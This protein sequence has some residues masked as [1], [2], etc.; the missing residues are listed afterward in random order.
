MP[1][2][3]VRI[4]IAG[5][6]VEAVVDTGAS[7][8]VIGERIVKKLGCWKRARKVRVRQGDGS[9]LA[10]GKYVVNTTLKVFSEGSLLGRF[11]LDA[12]VL[13]IGKWD[14][15]LELSWL[16]EHRFWVDTQAR[17]LRKDRSILVIPCSIRWIPSVTVLD[18]DLKPL[19]DGEIILIIDAS[20][21]YSRYAQ[22]FST[23]QAARLPE[24]KSWDHAIPLQ[25]PKAKIPTGAIYK[26]TW[27]EDEALQTYLWENLPTSK[28]R[29]SRSAAGAPILFVKK[30]DG[31]LRLCVDY[32]AL[33]RLTIPNKYPLPLISELL[34]KTRGGKWF[35]RLDLKNGYKFI[36]IAVG[37][38]W[39]T[40]FR[41]KKGLFE[42]TV[43]PFGLT[44]A[45]A[46][47]Q[48]MIDT[49][50]KDMEG[51]IWYLD[52]FLIY[53]GDS[54]EEH[55]QLVEQVLQQCIKHS[56]A[57]NLTKSE[58]HVQETLFLGHM[59]NGQ[60]VQMDPTKLE[61]MSKWPTPTKKKEVQAFLGFANY[62]RR[63]I[64]NYSGKARPLI[65]LTRNVPFSWAQAQQQSFDELK[66]LFLSAP[67]LTQFDR[68]L[69]TIVETDASNQ[70]ISGILWQ[71][72]IVN[73][74]KQLHPTEY[75]A[76]TLDAT[77]HNWPIHDKELFAIVDSFRKWRDWLVGVPVNV[78]TDYQGLQYFNTKKKL[79]SRQAS[80]YLKMSEFIY[81]IHYR[82][83][84][85]MGKA[86]GLSRCSGEEKSGMEARFFD[87]G[88]LLDLEEDDAEERGD[89]D[90]ME[91]EAIDVASWKK[92]N[93]LCLMGDANSSTA[94]RLTESILSP[95]W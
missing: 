57:V 2:L 84:S 64:T 49:I 18:L 22:C 3:T 63:F 5:D 13:D 52:D 45:P 65:D 24:H 47:F 33:N 16:E 77:Q 21:R 35:T 86:D 66:Q 83:G 9:T 46:T 40:A 37:D 76:K 93:G 58:F 39:K 44:N 11:T 56:L 26:T 74:V 23:E 68:C 48:E 7:G 75:Y 67:I 85:K 79:N 10:G 69:E 1:L 6:E 19:E 36:R 80:W 51:C 89:A 4:T 55:Q 72:H 91:L 17:C 81:H 60:Q 43:M 61:A 59:I 30:K 20:E 54:E 87:K 34:D 32:R 88:Q 70:A 92:K 15:I 94:G 41:T 12:E 71:Y 42:Y 73:R 31:S 29:R 53:G 8:P 50:F 90:D 78:Y 28:V 25:D 38:E 95:E 14:V 27:E 82:P 62:Y